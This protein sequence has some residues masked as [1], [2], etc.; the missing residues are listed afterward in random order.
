MQYKKQTT[1]QKIELSYKR[2]RNSLVC[3]LL[4]E[5]PSLTSKQAYRK[6]EKIMRSKQKKTKKSS[7][8]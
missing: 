4:D 2:R 3:R 5:D 7:A 1:K 6:A 8:K